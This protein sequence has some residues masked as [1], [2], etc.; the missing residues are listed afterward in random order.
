MQHVTGFLTCL[1]P[2][3]IVSVTSIKCCK[4]IGAA[5]L[6][7]LEFKF[8]ALTLQRK[9]ALMGIFQVP[10]E[11]KLQEAEAFLVYYWLERICPVFRR[12]KRLCFLADTPGYSWTVFK[13]ISFFV[14][15]PH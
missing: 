4:G 1:G 8:K 5:F 11:T 15:L 3:A 2:G 13:G 12:F 10:A 14:F 9:I 7:W 6:A